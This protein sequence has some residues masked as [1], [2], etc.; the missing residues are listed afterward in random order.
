[1]S[2]NIL[3]TFRRCPYAMRARWAL[4]STKQSVLWREV[5]L[6]QKPK[7][8]LRVSPKA[9]IPVLITAEGT[10]VDESLKIM[11][12]A[13]ANSDI[14]NIQ[15]QGDKE[16]EE[17]IDYLIGI[18]DGIFKYHLDRYKY[19]NRYIQCDS[20]LHKSLAHQILIEW[21]TMISINSSSC[22]LV[23]G[24]ETLADWAIWPFVRQYRL[25]DSTGFDDDLDLMALRIWLEYYLNNSKFNT[26]MIKTEPW[27]PGH[28]NMYF[29]P[30]PNGF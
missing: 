23:N 30:R 26:L 9:T 16:A 17:K 13:L 14:S 25:V 6:K 24:R 11:R 8:L 21:N 10:V 12:W 18:N 4:L 28:S 19:A 7:E 5:Q 2:E 15:C 20:E 1:M 27:Q 22:W 3:Y 29:P